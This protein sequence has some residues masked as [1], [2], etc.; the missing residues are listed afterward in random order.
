MEE[1]F[2]NLGCSY[3]AEFWYIVTSTGSGGQDVDICGGPWFSLVQ[4]ILVQ[5]VAAGH[6]VV[7]TN[8]NLSSIRQFPIACLRS[9][10]LPTACGPA[11]PG[12]DSVLAGS[13]VL[14][15]VPRGI[16]KISGSFPLKNVTQTLGF[17][18]SFPT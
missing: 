14:D 5:N 2:P 4:D 1:A 7:Q 12:I 15:S 9:L 18:D 3:P 11:H 16:F 8:H 6:C 17:P 10:I 13:L